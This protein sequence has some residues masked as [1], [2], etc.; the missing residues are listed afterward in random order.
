[1]TSASFPGP[2]VAGT[3]RRHGARGAVA[4]P[5]AHRALRQSPDQQVLDP[6]E[7]VLDRPDAP[8]GVIE[9]RLDGCQPRLD[10]TELGLDRLGALAVRALAL[11][12]AVV[13]RRE[14]RPAVRAIGFQRGDPSLEVGQGGGHHDDASA[15]PGP[16]TV[17]RRG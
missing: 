2:G 3:R 5:R 13:D 8:A 10:G 4:A 6:G 15:V 16:A 9:L 17:R 14:H 7:V 12:Q 11:S 1:M